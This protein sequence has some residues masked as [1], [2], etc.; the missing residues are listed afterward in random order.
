MTTLAGVLG[1]PIAQSRSPALHGH[2]LDR[3]G[4][5][6]AYLPLHVPLPDLRATLA[7]L[8]QIGF[9]GVNVTMP[10]KEEAFALADEATERARI[11][12]AANTLRFRNGA[13][14][15]DNTDGHGFLAALDQGAP[16]WDAVGGAAVVLGAGGAARGIVAALLG[17]GIGRV[18]LANRNRARAEALA[19]DLAALPGEITVI[20]PAALPAALEGAALLANATS[21][22]MQ[23]NPPLEIDLA[24]LPEGATVT[25]IV[26]SPLETPL[27][28]AARA[29][30]LAAVDGLGMLLHQAAP[31]F[32]AWFGRAP[33]VDAELRA[34]VLGG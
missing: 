21:L 29:R 2:W 18:V 16:G 8:P 17:R 24:P 34:A 22:G 1:D 15:A 28:A 25:D 3:Y 7:L 12:G 26:Y 5:D 11:N 30:G 27:L 9:A 6:G 23:G 13:I 33:E 20:D 31:G 10:L 19:A 14:L 4:I 32:E